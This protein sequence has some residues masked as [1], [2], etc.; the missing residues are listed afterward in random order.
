MAKKQPV[1]GDA[2]TYVM[3]QGNNEE[4]EASTENEENKAEEKA[5]NEEEG[6]PEEESKESPKE[7]AKELYDEIMEEDPRVCKELYKLLK[8]KY[9]GE[10][11]EKKS[12]LKSEAGSE[13]E[14][15]TSGMP[16]D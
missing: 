14:Y 6:S 4:E 15:N 9:E 10:E 13:D 5:E 11:K 7:E 12:E 16:T 1:V 2:T 8:D 3:P